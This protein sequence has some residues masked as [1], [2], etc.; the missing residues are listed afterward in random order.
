[1]RSLILASLAL[2][3]SGHVR[4]AE[5][6][7]S[8]QPHWGLKTGVQFASHPAGFGGGDGG[9]RGLLRVGAPARPGG[10]HLLVNFVAVEPVVKSR[11]GFS[12]L[13]WSRMD[14]AK[15]K[16]FWAGEPRRTFPAPEVEE[17]E[18][19]IHVEAFDNGARIRL[20]VA[21]RS[22]APDEL[23]LTVHTQPG[24]APVESCI[25]TATMGN[26]V[27]ARRLWLREEVL[28]SLA[29]YPGFRGHGFTP[30]TVRPLPHLARTPGGDVTAAITGD[31]SDPAGVFP[32]PGTRRWHYAGVPVT[33][34]WRVP[35]A[36]VSPDLCVAANARHTYWQSMQP[37][38]GGLAF[39]NFEMR[40]PFREGQTF[41]FG[42]TRRTPSELGLAPAA[43]A[44]GRGARMLA[45]APAPVDNP[46]KGLA[47]Y[48]G[49]VRDRFPHSM[50]FFYLPF[51]ALV[52][53]Y[54]EFDWR[55]LE[56]PLNAV[57]GRGHQA[58]FRVFLEYPGHSDVIPAFLIR[59]GLKV[60]RYLNTNT[61]PFPRREVETPD[62][63]DANLRRAMKGFIAALGRRYDGDP[64]V[65]FITAGLLGTWGEWH[66]WPRDDLFANREVQAEVMDAYEA[67]FKT[68]P[69]LLRYPAGTD[70]PTKAPNATR[71]FGYHD[72]S[73]AWATLDTGRKGDDWFFM[74]LLK[75]AGPA[76][77]EKWK[78][79]PIGGEI[80]P[81]AWGRCFDAEPGDPRIQDFRACV[82]ATH[83]TWL[84][85]SGMFKKS[86]ARNE[87]RIRRAEEAVRRMGY[88]F[89][90]RAATL[91]PTAD[92][93]LNAKVEVENRGV[94]PFY[95]DWPVEFGL[96]DAGGAVV[97]TV[98]GSGKLT[99]LLPGD[100]AREWTG[101]WDR[102][103]IPRA[104]FKV[105]LRVPNPL[106]NA[107][108][109]RFANRTQD[110]DAKGWLTLGEIG[111]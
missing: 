16:R 54:D 61:Q 59:D 31:E 7:E 107:N 27:R 97:K 75:A 2:L 63:G 62:Y 48:A 23:R 17:L 64:R 12:E 24:S 37:I 78:I 21:Q 46:L 66:D 68:T 71:R 25:L 86:E 22:D 18:V 109:V 73:F 45:Y 67:A 69:V 105:G 72:D 15:G 36:C 29:L 43:D 47:P 79:Q 103:D 42:V 49:D 81:E 99:G 11:R 58:I 85:D 87:E 98:R 3:M 106:P 41:V 13:E 104:R 10:G 95:Y 96:I 88:E 4:A 89:H 82:E 9:P 53:G 55:P 84:M 39:E 91:V 93:G 20:L 30:H 108:P 92:G 14:N 26:L 52:K 1:M 8:P 19:P 5:W 70:H 76:A 35:E 110:A 111:P 32:F 33:Q 38:P 90:V 51:S 6:I 83:V 40:M 94:A 74:A 60:H 101:A 100:P 77:A 80:R 44:L 50:E 57:A 56:D 34:Y 65:G 102:S 28:S